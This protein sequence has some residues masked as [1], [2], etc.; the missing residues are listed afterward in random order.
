[1]GLCFVAGVTGGNARLTGG[2]GEGQVLPDAFEW[3]SGEGCV[4]RMSGVGMYILSS[5][6]P[7]EGAESPVSGGLLP[8]GVLDSVSPADATET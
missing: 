8:S 2:I 7:G 5:N 1:M 3:L 4:P 6:G